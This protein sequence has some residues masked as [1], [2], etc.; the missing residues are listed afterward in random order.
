MFSRNR[1]CSTGRCISRPTINFSYTSNGTPY[2][3]FAEASR[4]SRYSDTGF[5]NT[6]VGGFS[7]SNAA[8]SYAPANYQ[9]APPPGVSPSALGAA[10]LS[11]QL[12]TYV[13][14]SSPSLGP[15][16]GQYQSPGT[17]VPL[18]EALWQLKKVRQS[19]A[20]TI[21]GGA[22]AMTLPPT[23]ISPR[24]NSRPMEGTV[25]SALKSGAFAFRRGKYGLAQVE[26]RE[27]MNRGCTDARSRLGL[28]LAEF[29]LGQYEEAANVVQ[30][31]LIASPSL[32]RSSLSVRSAY[33]R[34]SDFD[35]HLRGLLLA[36]ESQPDNSE[37]LLL[38]GFMQYYSGDKS[39]GLANLQR[40]AS[41][42]SAD[43]RIVS[44]VRQL[45]AT[46]NP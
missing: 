36:L 14:P 26:Y 44:Y 11:R 18:G 12:S 19:G 28:A 9:L 3:G 39:A 17:G 38:A 42:A 41:S 16:P 45:A 25:E 13:A 46:A 8:N 20:Q 23:D 43:A 30:S 34:Q 29:A 7:S 15:G 2:D 40:Y 1:P 32:N 37:Y 5:Q 27:A 4:I 24:L 21:S 6:S 31:D 10:P 33:R 22:G 35:T